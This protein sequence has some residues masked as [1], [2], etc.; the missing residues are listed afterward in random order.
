MPALLHR[1]GCNLGEWYG[2]PPSCAHWANFESVHGVRCYENIAANAKYRRVLV[3]A[4]CLVE[5]AC[6]P[7]VIKVDL[8]PFR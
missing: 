1:L 2:V 4:L 6:S 3:L 5:I 7:D 8:L